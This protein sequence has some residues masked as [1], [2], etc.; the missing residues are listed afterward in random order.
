MIHEVLEALPV[1][2]APRKLP[3]DPNPN[4]PAPARIMRVADLTSDVRLFELRFTDS[5]LAVALDRQELA[6]IAE[7]T[8][9]LRTNTP[10][11]DNEQ[12]AGPG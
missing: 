8:A 4:V 1:R 7:R 9:Q 12:S 2:S 10:V 5:R 3:T 6:Q 11:P